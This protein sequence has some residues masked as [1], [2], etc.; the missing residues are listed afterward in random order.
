[1]GKALIRGQDGYYLAEF[2]EILFSDL[3]V[4]VRRK[5]ITEQ[6]VL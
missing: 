2:R 6:G 4:A 3:K 1:M 5:S